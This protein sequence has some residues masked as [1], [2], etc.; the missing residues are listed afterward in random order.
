MQIDFGHSWRWRVERVRLRRSDRILNR[1]RWHP[2]ANLFNLPQEYSNERLYRAALHSPEK[3]LVPFED[4]CAEF[5]HPSKLESSS[6]LIPSRH[7]SA[8]DG[9]NEDHAIELLSRRVLLAAKFIASKSGN[10]KWFS[11]V[12]SIN[13]VIRN[14]FPTTAISTLGH[15]N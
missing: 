12:S 5:I 15:V 4:G 6:L 3:R 8:T 1:D 10:Y 13:N 2:V 11:C 7:L 14:A 9:V